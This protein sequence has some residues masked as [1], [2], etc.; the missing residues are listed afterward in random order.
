[1]IQISQKLI[2]LCIAKSIKITVAESCTGGIISSAIT[3]I[4]GSSKVFD[5]GFITYSNE[6]KIDLLS[7]QTEMLREHGAVSL[8]IASEMAIGAIKHSHADIAL[9]TTGIAGPNS[10]GSNKPVGLVY[11]AILSKGKVKCME[12]YFEGNRQQIRELASTFGIELLLDAATS[13]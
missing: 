5:C 1:M 9:A 10:D 11:F 6:S 8:V 7:I 4:S 2:D 12:K 13:F 3:S